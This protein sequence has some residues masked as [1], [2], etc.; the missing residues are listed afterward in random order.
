MIL[1]AQL[2]QVVDQFDAQGI[3]YAI[4]GGIAVGVYGFPRLTIDIDLLI[5]ESELPRAKGAAAAVGFDL[6]TGWLPLSQKTDCRI[7]RL[8]KIEGEK[9]LP[10]DLMIVESTPGDFWSDRKEVLVEGRRLKVISLSSLIQMKRESSRSKD[11]IDV[12]VLEE[13]ARKKS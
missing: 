8:I 2:F 11:R 13:I 1:S 3:E 9:F 7:F 10:L 12:E 6:E 5:N 4:C